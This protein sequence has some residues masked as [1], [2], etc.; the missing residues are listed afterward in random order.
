MIKINCPN[1]NTQYELA[2]DLA[3]R[4]VQCASCNNKFYLPTT[5]SS[6]SN[7]SQIT[8]N[9]KKTAVASKQSPAKKINYSPK[10]P[11]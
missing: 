4:K 3:G 6:S 10:L 1:C 9:R 7:N 2:D 8:K 5:P 11:L